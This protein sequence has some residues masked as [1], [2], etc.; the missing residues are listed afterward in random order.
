MLDAEIAESANANHCYDWQTDGRALLKHGSGIEY[1]SSSV[2]LM[3]IFNARRSKASHMTTYNL[4][5]GC[6]SIKLPRTH[7][8]HADL[9]FTLQQAVNIT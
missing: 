6:W 5:M 8:M 9:L 4:T 1:F 3:S 2:R 7:C